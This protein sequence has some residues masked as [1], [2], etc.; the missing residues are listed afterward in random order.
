MYVLHDPEYL[1]NHKSDNDGDGKIPYEIDEIKTPFPEQ[2][3]RDFK[4]ALQLRK[5]QNQ[6]VLDRLIRQHQSATTIM[7]ETGINPMVVSSIMNAYLREASMLYA[8]ADQEQKREQIEEAAKITGSV[9]VREELPQLKAEY[10][11]GIVSEK[12]E[13]YHM[14]FATGEIVKDYQRIEQKKEEEAE[15]DNIWEGLKDDLG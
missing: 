5:T 14:D 11:K 3:A 1:K 7:Y 4:K 2:L 13:A 12:V 10:E 15:E 8:R 9:E 6:E